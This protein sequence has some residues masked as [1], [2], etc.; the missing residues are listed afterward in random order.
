MSRVTPLLLSSTSSARRPIR[1]RRS[2]GLGDR[3][4]RVVLGERQVVLGAQLLVESARHAGV[5]QQEGPPRG[6]PGVAGCE[7]SCDRLG[8]GHGRDA[9][10]SV[11]DASVG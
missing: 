2:G 10:T 4:Q 8:H 1:I 6:E 9:T 5:R 7:R 3:Q 11:A